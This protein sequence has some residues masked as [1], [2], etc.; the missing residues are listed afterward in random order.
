VSLR[1]IYPRCHVEVTC[2]RE[3]ARCIRR[4][5]RYL[6]IALALYAVPWRP[7][8]RYGFCFLQHVDD[9]LDGHLAWPGEPLDRVDQLLLQV[10][11]E[12]FEASPIGELG[13]C[14]WVRLPAEGKDQVLALLHEMRMDRLRVRDGLLWEAAELR[15]HLQRTFELSLNVLFVGMGAELRAAD[16]PELVEVLGWCSTFRDLE[17]D[18][19]LGLV[20]IPAPVVAASGASLRQ[21]AP[22]FLQWEAEEW[23]R[24][25]ELLVRCGDRLDGLRG[26]SGENVA[27]RF[28]QSVVVFERRYSKARTMTRQVGQS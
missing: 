10:R 15:Q 9:L 18:L 19:S 21:D 26:R 8:L 3:F 13:R 28:W 12:R 20:N 5:R 23:Q 2:V 17:D 16:V 22:A 7:L 25:R 27:R 14:F 1:W 11:S 4:H 24:A 6:V